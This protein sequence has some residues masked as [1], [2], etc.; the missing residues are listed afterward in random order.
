MNKQIVLILAFSFKKFTM[1]RTTFIILE[2]HSA[3]S[4]FVTSVVGRMPPGHIYQKASKEMSCGMSRRTLNW[5][6]WTLTKTI[7]S[8]KHYK[9]HLSAENCW[10]SRYKPMAILLL[11]GYGSLT[12]LLWYSFLPKYYNHILI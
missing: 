10:L 7:V 9:G 2:I 3:L 8:S 11:T 4:L 6:C 12:D 1:Q 5:A